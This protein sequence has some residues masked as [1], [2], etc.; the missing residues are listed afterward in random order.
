MSSP[1]APEVTPAAGLG[2]PRWVRLSHWIGAASMITLAFSG[3]VILMAHPRLYW[4]R[5]ATT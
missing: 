2:H 5:S 4:G 3:F 1:S